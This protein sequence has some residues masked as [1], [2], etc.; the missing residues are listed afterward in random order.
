MR[1]T[2]PLPPIVRSGSKR[3]SR[4]VTSTRQVEYH[5]FKTM[6]KSG[7]KH[8]SLPPL[9]LSFSL[10]KAA[11][12]PLY[13]LHCNPTTKPLESNKYIEHKP[14]TGTWTPN[15][16]WWLPLHSPPRPSLSLSSF[17]LSPPIP[18]SETHKHFSHPLYTAYTTHHALRSSH[19]RS[20]KETIHAQTAV[21]FLGSS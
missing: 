21:L 12:R 14:K 20:V 17:L 13:G 4:N 7:Y 18:V 11:H 5:S 3:D 6:R 8:Y 10:K 9:V 2:K 16:L 15:T 19:S 1:E